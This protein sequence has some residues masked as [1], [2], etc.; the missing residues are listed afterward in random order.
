[1]MNVKWNL[2]ST[3][4]MFSLEETFFKYQILFV[5]VMDFS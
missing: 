3:K 4:M 5:A 2:D 1:M